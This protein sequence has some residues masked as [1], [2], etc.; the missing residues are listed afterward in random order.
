MSG[1]KGVLVPKGQVLIVKNCK[2]SAC[3]A[4]SHHFL[5]K[6]AK[7]SCTQPHPRSHCLLTTRKPGLFLCSQRQR[8]R[9]RRR[10]RQRQ[11]L[12]RR[13][14]RGGQPSLIFPLECFLWSPPVNSHCI[15]STPYWTKYWFN[16][17]PLVGVFKKFLSISPFFSKT[18]KAWPKS[19][20]FDNK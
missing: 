18:F 10:Q 1:Y 2:C 6:Q 9:Q 11:R 17:S 14:R 20:I 19:A 7:L 8:R 5:G 16:L 13:Q 4:A 3:Q 15:G 12:R